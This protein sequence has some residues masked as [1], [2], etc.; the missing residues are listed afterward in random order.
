MKNTFCGVVQYFLIFLYYILAFIFGVVAAFFVAP[1]WPMI[2]IYPKYQAEQLS[3]FFRSII[4]FLLVFMGLVLWPVIY[5]FSI[6]PGSCIF[7]YK[8]FSQED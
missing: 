2:I 4:I 6:V 7:A 1:A 8:F 5:A 3:G